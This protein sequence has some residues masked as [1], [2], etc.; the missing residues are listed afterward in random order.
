MNDGR[1]YPTNVTLGDGS[2]VVLS[3]SIDDNFADRASR[4]IPT[5]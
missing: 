3:G 5:G 1:W 4:A 2:T